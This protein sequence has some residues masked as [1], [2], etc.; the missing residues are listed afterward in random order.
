MHRDDSQVGQAPDR[1]SGDSSD[2]ESDNKVRAPRGPIGA[3]AEAA[4]GIHAVDMVGAHQR[5]ALEHRTTGRSDEEGADRPGSEPLRG[6]G[7]HESGY[8]GKAGKPRTSSDG[9][10]PSEQEA[11]E[12]DHSPQPKG[13]KS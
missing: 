2:K 8:G 4:E 13:G 9:R 5:S 7:I 10:E 3:G 12:T 6:T 11:S 1:P